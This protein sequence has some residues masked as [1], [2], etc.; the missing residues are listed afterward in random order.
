MTSSIAG[1]V[2][3]AAQSSYCAANGFLDAFAR[4]RRSQ[5]QAATSLAL[6]A[7]KDVGFFADHEDHEDVTTKLGYMP[8]GEDQMLSLVDYVVAQ[9]MSG[10]SDDLMRNVRKAHIFTGII[11]QT[12]ERH[13][14]N[15]MRDPRA[16]GLKFAMEREASA[17]SVGN[18]SA[19]SGQGS[20]RLTSINKAKAAKD[21]NG[22]LGLVEQEIGERLAKLVQ[23]PVDRINK[24]TRLSDI[25]MDSMLAVEARQSATLGVNVPMVDFMMS[26]STVGGIAK[27]IVDGMLGA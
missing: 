1:S 10:S 16:L 22:L 12:P 7:I 21:R 13:I 11:D 6:G 15:L 19:G 18:N 24:G 20:Q 23:T 2:G 3:Q 9:E 26:S 5:G 14:R 8:M 17:Q 25:G 4:Y 27:K